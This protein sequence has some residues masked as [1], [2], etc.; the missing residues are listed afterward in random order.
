[1][2]IKTVTIEQAPL[3]LR[4]SRTLQFMLFLLPTLIMFYQY[5]GLTIGDFFLIQ[6]LFSIAVFL[7]EIPTGY[8]G[9]L[10]S[11]KKVLVYAMFLFFLGHMVWFLF[12]GFFAVFMGEFL[13][14]VSMSLYS[15]TAEAYLHDALEKQ[16][17]EENILEEISKLDTWTTIGTAFATFIGAV[18]YSHLGPDNTLIIEAVIMFLSFI[19]I[20]LLPEI[21]DNQRKVEEGKSKIK[22]ILDIVKYSTNHPEIKWL[23]IYPAAYGSGTFILMWGLQPLMELKGVAIALF[24]IFMGA[25]QGFRA[26]FAHFSNLLAKKINTNKLSI[27]LFYI[28]IIGFCA[29]FIAPDINNK[30]A[31]YAFL[32]IMGL[33]AG[34]QICL[35]LVTSAMIH[36][37]IKSNERATVLSVNA[38]V[39][40][41]GMAFSTI[42]VKFLIDGYNLQTTYIIMGSVLILITAYSLIKL[43]KLKM[44]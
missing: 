15:G 8:I 31:I 21:N 34:S 11:R 1:M 28:L 2:K 6:G 29:S 13:M 18:M 25:N 22:D 30:I 37:R 40:R 7:L 39:G 43:L 4:I 23:M 14:A 32:L 20:L 26:L 36:K 38:M 19:T 16:H 27:L 9:D 33:A 24:G 35:R 17:K 5:K 10:F 3:V 42:S 12:R 44:I 41:I